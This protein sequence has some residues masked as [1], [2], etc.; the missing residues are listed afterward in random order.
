MQL[1]FIDR[2]GVPAH[3]GRL[4]KARRLPNLACVQHQKQGRV[5]DERFQVADQLGR[6]LP[7]QGF[8]QT[9]QLAKAAVQRRGYEVHYPGEEVGEEP[10]GV[11]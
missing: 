7:P 1:D 6:R 8:Q 4:G 11:A 10:P 3:P 2:E 5:D 9:Q